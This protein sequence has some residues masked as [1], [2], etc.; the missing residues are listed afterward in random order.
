[1]GT[2]PLYFTVFDSTF[3]F[4]ECFHALNKN[5]KCGF[6]QFLSFWDVVFETRFYG[7][8]KRLKNLRRNVITRLS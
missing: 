2:F 7:L 6:N 3:S 1:M 4:A 5:R 8:V